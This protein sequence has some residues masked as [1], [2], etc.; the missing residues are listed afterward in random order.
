[1]RVQQLEGIFIF[2]GAFDLPAINIPVSVTK[3]FS[4][5]QRDQAATLQ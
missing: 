2:I 3:S 4:K 5:K 1:M